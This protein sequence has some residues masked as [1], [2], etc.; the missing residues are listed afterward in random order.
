MSNIDTYKPMSQKCQRRNPLSCVGYYRTYHKHIIPE[1]ESVSALKPEGLGQPNRII[2]TH[3]ATPCL[4]YDERQYRQ[5][6][7]ERIWEDSQHCQ[8]IEA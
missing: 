1:S 4:P 3:G 5:L 2:Q 7:Y 6:E 8:R